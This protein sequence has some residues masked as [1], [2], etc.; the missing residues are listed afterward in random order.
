CGWCSSVHAAPNAAEWINLREWG[1][2]VCP[3]S[4]RDALGAGPESAR[5]IVVMDS[6]LARF[7]S[8]R[9]DEWGACPI[10]VRSVERCPVSLQGTMPMMSLAELQRRIDSGD[11]SAD[12]AISQSREAIG[13]RDKSIGA[14]VCLDENARA[15]NAGPL[16]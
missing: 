8:P 14:F 13:A 4:F 9:N 1:R 5:P 7:C 12:A 2:G 6:G 3:S 11:L 16:R 15:A 10:P